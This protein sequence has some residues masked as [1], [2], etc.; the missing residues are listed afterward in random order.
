MSN[1]IKSKSK[2]CRT[3]GADLWGR[4]NKKIRRS[5][6]GQHGVKSGSKKLTDY[7]VQLSEKQKFRL[8]YGD[9]REKQ[10]YG[11]YKEATRKKGD[12]IENLVGLLE[13]RLDA[14]IF[15]TNFAPTIYAA[16]QIVSHKRVKVNN[17]VVNIRSYV[18]KPGDVI[19][20]TDA[21]KQMKV[22]TDSITANERPIPEYIEM[23][24]PNMS[25]KYLKVPMFEEI[26]YAIE[27][28]PHLVIEFY[29]RS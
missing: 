26:P 21:A 22:I 11:I 6:P 28:H 20:I 17:R 27:M 16:R 1:I 2:I 23:D 3:I 19:E 18:L 4:G 25:A 29:S 5:R 14:F 9:I 13:S 10:F 24:I 8:Y 12:T 7:G 15:R